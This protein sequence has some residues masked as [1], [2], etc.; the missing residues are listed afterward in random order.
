MDFKNNSNKS[1][2]IKWLGHSS[3]LLTSSKNTKI[4]IDPYK[5]FA[6]Y[7][8]PNV[9]PD[10]V[11][12][13][14]SHSDHSFTE[15]IDTD[16][17]LINEFGS[18]IEKDIEF[19]GIETFHDTVNGAE[20]GTNIVFNITV[21]NI[22]ICHLGDIG[23]TLSNEKLDQIGDV[24]ILLIPVGGTYTIDNVVAKIIVNQINPKI[25][26]PMHYKTKALEMLG[27]EF[28][29]VDKFIDTMNTDYETLDSITVSI[30]T[31]DDFKKLVILN[32]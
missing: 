3:F 21:D 17:V 15:N 19:N 24:D 10:I 25:V 27:D 8:L 32:Y 12:S 16:F 2:S 5:D 13:S 31:L 18:Y 20:K 9:Y 1:V 6:G 29:K 28:L 14:H 4:L 30:D 7:I 11:V 26:I 23:H 22:N